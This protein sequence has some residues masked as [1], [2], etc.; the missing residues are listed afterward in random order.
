MGLFN[1]DDY[2]SL[3]WAKDKQE[4]IDIFHGLYDEVLGKVTQIHENEIVYFVQDESTGDIEWSIQQGAKFQSPKPKALTV[5]KF[6][7]RILSS[8]GKV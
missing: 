3:I 8:L 6:E 2:S 7:N 4:A 5:S 1:I